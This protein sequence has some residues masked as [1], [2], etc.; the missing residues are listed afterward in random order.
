[1]DEEIKA[2]IELISKMHEIKRVKMP[3]FDTKTYTDNEYLLAIHEI[4]LDFI[5]VDLAAY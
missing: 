3:K 5:V 2:Y 4:M 1:M